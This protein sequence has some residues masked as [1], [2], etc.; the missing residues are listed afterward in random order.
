MSEA[1]SKTAESVS[2]AN[3]SSSESSVQN[4]N[5]LPGDDLP[6]SVLEEIFSDDNIF[7]EIQPAN[8]NNIS[9]IDLHVT[10]TQNQQLNIQVPCPKPSERTPT[11]MYNPTFNNCVMH[12]VVN[13]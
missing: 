1:L 8:P 13:K 12:F 9:N 3:A 10:E 7:E 6:A 4:I 5:M 11:V 2:G